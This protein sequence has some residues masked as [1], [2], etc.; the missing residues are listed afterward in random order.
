[1]FREAGEPGVYTVE[2]E[3]VTLISE[4]GR[5]II[6]YRIHRCGDNNGGSRDEKD[7]TGG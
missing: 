3:P 1:M 5:P 7:K 4:R 6:G 2:A